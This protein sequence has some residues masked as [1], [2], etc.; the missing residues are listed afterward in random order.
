MWTG[1]SVALHVTD[2]V[3]VADVHT[4]GTL[5]RTS[6]INYYKLGDAFFNP[7]TKQAPP[8]KLEVEPLGYVHPVRS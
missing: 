6:L 3:A 8:L 2:E 1:T 7:V 5:S 4:R